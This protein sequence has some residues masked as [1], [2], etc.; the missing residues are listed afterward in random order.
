ML[1]IIKII[2]IIKK[3]KRKKKKKKKNPLILTLTSL[4][5]KTVTF[6][7]SA[8]PDKMAHIEPS[9]LDL[10]CLPFCWFMVDTPICN[11]GCAQNQRWKSPLH[12]LR[13]LW[14]EIGFN[15]LKCLKTISLPNFFMHL[16][17]KPVWSESALFAYAILS[18]KVTQEIESQNYIAWYGK[19]KKPSFTNLGA[20]LT[21]VWLFIANS[22]NSDWT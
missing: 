17:H 13:V 18:E 1:F 11:N 2:I 22:K 5:T 14:V 20:Y 16:I 6:A 21:K 7:N 4:Q 3:K 15:V 8:D 12:K 9:C 19:T 10:H